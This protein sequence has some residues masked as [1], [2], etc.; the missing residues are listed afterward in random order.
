MVR[1]LSHRPDPSEGSCG[2]PKKKRLFLYVKH[3]CARDYVHF[4]SLI[5][6]FLDNSNSMIGTVQSSIKEQFRQPHPF[7]KTSSFIF[8]VF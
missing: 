6:S 4:F 8:P 1:G 3:F 5:D 2:G 7:N